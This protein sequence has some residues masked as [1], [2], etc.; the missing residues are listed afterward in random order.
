MLVLKDVEKKPE[1]SAFGLLPSK[2][3]KW[4]SRKIWIAPSLIDNLSVPEKSGLF[5]PKNSKFQKKN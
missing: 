4:G 5:S 3:R 2:L 1:K